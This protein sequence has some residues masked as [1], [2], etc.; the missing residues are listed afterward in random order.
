MFNRKRKVETDNRFQLEMER[1]QL[2]FADKEAEEQQRLQEL[3]EE[4]QAAVRQHEKVNSQHN[5]LGEAVRQ[6]EKRFDNVGELSEKTSDKSNDLF[7]KGRS[8]EKNAQQMVQEASD[9]TKEVQGTA[10][11]IKELGVQIQASEKNM[12]N[13]SERSVEIQSIV[14]VIEDIAAQTNLLA[15]N[16]SIEAARAGESGKG[17]AVVA[18]E[19]RKLAES[20]SDSTANI[21]TLTNALREEIEQAL[22]ATRK[23]A[24]LVEKGISVSMETA[25]KIERILG[26]VEESKLD[27]T[28]IQ[29]MIEEQKKLSEAVKR[30][31]SDATTLFAEAQALIIDHIEN[32]KELDIRLEK[33][34]Y[35]L[36]K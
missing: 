35:Q 12:T 19:V 3:R 4:L 28:S 27:I 6:I 13:L 18:Q 22:E 10:E 11:V 8:L 14:G 25:D 1:M 33:G 34:I 36:S 24:A 26:T 23:S 21:Q 5:V 16:A 29:E 31:L 20:T 32:A 17:F 7:E 15:L 9:G 2:E 30:E